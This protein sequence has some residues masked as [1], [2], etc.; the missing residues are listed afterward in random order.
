MKSKFVTALIGSLVA[1]SAFAQQKPLS[2]PAS[3]SETFGGKKV[4]ISYSA[5]SR[6]DRVIIGGLVP[7]GKVW[8]T[9]ANAATTLT[10]EAELTFGKIKLARG[11]YT[12]FT[13]PDKKAWVLIVNKETGQWGTQ[14]DASKDFGRTPMT[15]KPLKDTVEMFKI[16]LDKKNEKSGVLRLVWEKTEVSVPFSVQ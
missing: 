1:L 3:V 4:A 12:L 5:P 7:F 15:V 8:R 9:G 16:H 10:T 14:Y 6:R 2:P 11:T 13:L